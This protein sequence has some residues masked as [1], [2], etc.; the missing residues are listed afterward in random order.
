M[1]PNV[2]W[3]D[4]FS[5]SGLG[6]GSWSCRCP[7]AGPGATEHSPRHAIVFV[8]R[9]GFV[10]HLNGRAVHADPNHV[11]FFNASEEYRVS[12]P[13]AGGDD[14]TVFSLD[15]QN[16]AELL[17][18][19][20]VPWSESRSLPARAFP[21]DSSTFLAHRQL[22]AI[23]RASASNDPLA[24]EEAALAL[25]QQALESCAEVPGAGE[26]ARPGTRRH[27][28][29]AVARVQAY[30]VDHLSD[31]VGLDGLAGIAGYS[32]YHLTRV[33]SAATGLSMHQYRNR[34]RLRV[35]L[36]HLANPQVDL[37]TLAFRVGFSSHSHFTEA[38][39]AEFG[40]TPSGVRRTFGA[41]DVEELGRRLDDPP[42]P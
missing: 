10:R 26:A 32:K 42:E 3:R 13:T 4:L 9:G 2:Q 40:A 22:Y 39:R 33:F 11:L 35:A 25:L 29:R 37:S 14:C 27:R 17:D 16:L 23:L 15:A 19:V 5:V 34:L 20:D 24:L 18:S 41:V 1:Y 8:R 12:H 21:V 30:L 36:E 6:V 28:R 38:F 7:D 31:P